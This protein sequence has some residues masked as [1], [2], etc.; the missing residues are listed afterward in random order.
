MI[1]SIPTS[2]LALGRNLR[3][4]PTEWEKKLWGYLRNKNLGFRFKRQVRIGNY[5]VD[6]CCYEK[7]LII[8][9][10]GGHRKKQQIKQLD[11]DRTQFLAEEGYRVI[12]FWNSE[13]DH[14]LE[15]VLSEI[16][17]ALSQPHPRPLSSRGE[18]S[19]NLKSSTYA[20]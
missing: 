19:S 8:E 20:Q 13:I 10:D 7:R 18:G 11:S 14:G 6:F 17:T 1:G 4:A 5:L 16:L 3:K 9:L 12:R 2:L 15:S